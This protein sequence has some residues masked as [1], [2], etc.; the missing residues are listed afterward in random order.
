MNA[1]QVL[2]ESPAALPPRLAI[3]TMQ[4]HLRIVLQLSKQLGEPE[5][6][7][8]VHKLMGRAEL[9]NADQDK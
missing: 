6:S 8:E 4:S 1:A 9:L 3:T 5:F 2:R 7:A